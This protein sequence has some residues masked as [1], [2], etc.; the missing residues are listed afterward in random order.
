MNS[1]RNLRRFAATLATLVTLGAGLPSCVESDDPG[2]DHAADINTSKQ[3]ELRRA[4][5]VLWQ[6]H[7]N[8]TVRAIV[9]GA[10]GLDETGPVITALQ[11]N[12]DKIGD[13]IKPYY[14]DEAG[15]ALA[16]LLHE[17]IDTAVAT[18][19]AA[20]GG[21]DAELQTAAEAFYANGDEIAEFLSNA[22]PDNW[23]LDHMK[24]MMKKHLDQ[25]IELA[26]LQ[27]AGD[28][29]QALATYDSYIHHILIGMADMQSNGIIAQFPDQF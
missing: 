27:L 17:H 20:I 23:P 25:V 13:A 8:L 29:E 16:S 24:S 15:D 28:H 5:R 21:D 10:A 18:L 26:T 1:S 6:E 22:N 19:T 2:H 4:F 3:E 14:G 11:A 12:Q 7:G 9:A